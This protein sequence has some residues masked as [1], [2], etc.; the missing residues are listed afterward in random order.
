MLTV[1]GVTSGYGKVPVLRGVSLEAGAGEITALIGS[2]GAGKTTTLR[3]ILR[4]LPAWG[5]AIT[6]DGVPLDGLSPPEVIAR[7]IAL[8]PEGRKIFPGLTVLENLQV[9]AFVRW[10]RREMAR[11][12]EEIFGVFPRLAE[13]RAQRGGTLS[14]G[15]Q[16]MLAIGRGLMSRPKLLLLDEPSMGLAPLLVDHLFEVIQ[17]LRSRG[18]TILLVEQNARRALALANRAYVLES[19]EVVMTGSGEALLRDP[20]V[21][22]SYLGT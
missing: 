20:Q 4:V 12:L 14:G 9:G 5:G 1:D 10:D 17:D 22:D 2:N 16:Q 19:G 6:F 15:E 8:V 18:T 7:G 21:I 11:R 13:R 3:T